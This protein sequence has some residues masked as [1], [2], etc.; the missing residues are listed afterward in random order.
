MMAVI[1]VCAYVG[2]KITDDYSLY[3][4]E[5]LGFNEVSAAGVGTMALWIR[6][7]SAV[8]AGIV[9]DRFEGTK[10]II[11][12]F[13]LIIFGSVLTFLGVLEHL[14]WLA[15]T[16]LATSLIG[17]YGL[18]GIYFAVMKEA[19][20][21]L[22]ATGAAVGIISI[23]GYT[24]DIFM[25][26]LMGFLLD[27]FPGAAGHQYVFLVLTIFSIIGLLVSI[28]FRIITEGKTRYE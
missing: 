9:A 24:P 25:G 6:P 8:L 3:A 13:A 18:R 22:V 15:L 12:C 11:W 26:P 7:V 2:Y 20:I 10:A 19:G 28:R 4:N 21:P 16:I 23:V 14:A 27:N 5:V 1:I 17:V